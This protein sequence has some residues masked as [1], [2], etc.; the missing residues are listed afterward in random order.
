MKRKTKKRDN[1]FT[2]AVRRVVEARCGG[3]CEVASQVCTGTGEQ[4]HHRLRRSQGGEGTPANDYFCCG[5]CHT[6][7]HKEVALSYERGW[8]LRASA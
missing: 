6:F 5:P 4:H 3:R 7:L 8:L 2:P 1:E